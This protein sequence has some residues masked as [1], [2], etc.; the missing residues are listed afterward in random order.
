MS[1]AGLV[2]LRD[3]KLFLNNEYDPYVNLN[4]DIATKNISFLYQMYRNFQ[5][6]YYQRE[7][8]VPALSRKSSSEDNFMVV[9]DCSLQNDSALGGSVDVRLEIETLE[10]MPVDT[11]CQCLI[12]HDRIIQYAPFT[13]FIRRTLTK[14]QIFSMYNN[15]NNNN[16]K[17]N[18]TSHTTCVTLLLSSRYRM[19]RY[20]NITPK[21]R[22]NILY[23]HLNKL[24]ETNSVLIRREGVRFGYRKVIGPVVNHVRESKWLL[25]TGNWKSRSRN[26]RKLGCGHVDHFC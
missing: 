21:F 16:N 18:I 12:I 8:Y 1:L 11:I 15:N 9:F 23:T 7:D 24:E 4:L 17:I 6:S 5:Y 13:G 20:R 2:N 19:N 22:L 3:I 10:A 25:L 14:S 26:Y